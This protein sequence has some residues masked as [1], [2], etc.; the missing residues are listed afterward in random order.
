MH[1]CAVQLTVL[2]AS[3]APNSLAIV[4]DAYAALQEVKDLAPSFPYRYSFMQEELRELRRGKFGRFFT[5]C[6][7]RGNPKDSSFFLC[8]EDML[9]LLEDPVTLGARDRAHRQV[10]AQEKTAEQFHH[11]QADQQFETI[12][13]YD[14]M[15][16]VFGWGDIQVRWLLSQLGMPDDQAPEQSDIVSKE[17]KAL[18]AVVQRHIKTELEPVKK[19]VA[20]L[21]GQ[22]ERQTHLLTELLQ[23]SSK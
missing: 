3:R 22:L 18:E 13:T 8:T 5:C 14:D 20:T 17:T 15:T 7:V 1:S 4:F 21:Q 16:K 9:A 19:S 10:A 6:G 11:V 2:D 23:Y 12:I